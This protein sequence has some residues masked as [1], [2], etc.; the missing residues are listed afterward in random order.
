MRPTRP[1][2]QKGEIDGPRQTFQIGD[3]DQL[4][5]A[6]AYR[7]VV[8]AYRNGS[9]VL[10]K[11]IGDAVEGLENEQ[12]AGWY[13]GKP[14]IILQVHRQPGANIIKV[15]DAIAALLPVIEKTAP[16]ALSIALASDRTTT[17][18]AAVVE[19]QHTLAITVGLV[20][21]VIFLFLRKFWATVIP[22]V[23]L[24]VSLVATFA[25][26]AAASLQP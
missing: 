14:A 18:R 5:I 7:D 16:K 12:I 1:I 24:P 4:F 13:N 9:P 19:V 15:A 23:T 26:M 2:C 25:V 3:N 6:K 11:D 17:I 10:F 22:A 20:I 8:V 21:L